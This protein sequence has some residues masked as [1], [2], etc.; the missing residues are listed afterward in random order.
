MAVS[1]SSILTF[2]ESRFEE[3]WRLST[4]VVGSMALDVQMRGM[5]VFGLKPSEYL[6]FRIIASANVQ[7]HMR[8]HRHLGP[9]TMDVVPTNEG[10]VSISRRRIADASGLPRETVRRIVTKLLARGIVEKD[11]ADGLYV[12][13]G[14][15]RSNEYRYEASDLLGPVLKVVDQLARL[16]VLKYTPEAGS[17]TSD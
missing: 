16:G 4:Y 5:D 1:G 10:N 8:G 14:L 15:F 13:V 6:V 7:R 17:A 9:A 11:E 2:D 3:V 12:P